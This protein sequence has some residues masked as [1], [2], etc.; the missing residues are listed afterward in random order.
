MTPKQVKPH[1]TVVSVDLLLRLTPSLGLQLSAIEPIPLL[2]L[3][4]KLVYS[5]HL[6]IIINAYIQAC[7]IEYHCKHASIV[8]AP[9]QFRKTVPL[10]TGIVVISVS[11]RIFMHAFSS[12]LHLH[13]SYH[14]S[15]YG[16]GLPP[17]MQQV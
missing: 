13:H 5:I 14:N 15:Q 12:V 2:T 11:G 17:T 10:C 9:R 3:Q 6:H 1:S 4:C 7:T 16:L 8:T